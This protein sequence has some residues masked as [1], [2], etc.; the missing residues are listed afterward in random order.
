MVLKEQIKYD[1]VP[2]EGRYP[3]S[4]LQIAVRAGLIA[5]YVQLYSVIPV[6]T[7]LVSAARTGQG[8]VQLQ[9]III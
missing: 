9:N 4:E 6:S 2:A 1:Q 8:G 7:C 3:A 5:A